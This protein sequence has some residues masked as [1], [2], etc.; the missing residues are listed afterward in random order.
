LLAVA[1]A[2]SLAQPDQQKEREDAP[3]D[4]EHCEE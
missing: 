4:A 3:R 2:E 1:G